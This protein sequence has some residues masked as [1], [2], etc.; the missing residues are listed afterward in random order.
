MLPFKHKHVQ[1]SR[2]RRTRGPGSLQ[3]DLGP[4]QT[5]PAV[6]TTKVLKFECGTSG[7]YTLL[8]S[9]LLELLVVANSATTTSRLFESARLV[10]VEA[11]S[12]GLLGAAPEVISIAGF[13]VGPENR[14][15]SMSMGIK[16]AH[17]VWKPAPLSFDGL[18]QSNGVG[19][20]NTLVELVL[21]STAMLYVT[22]EFIMQCDDAVVDGPVPAGAVVGQIYGVPLDGFASGKIVSQD[23]PNLP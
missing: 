20:T 10:K 17:V 14:Q 22:I 12:L 19:E 3:D 7:T 5:D 21:P 23:F 4:F 6:R 11:W 2:T 16:P 1:H 13:G 8:T 9:T 18:W 15:S